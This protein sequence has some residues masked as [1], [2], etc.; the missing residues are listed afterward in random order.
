MKTFTTV[1]LFIIVGLAAVFTVG[2]PERRSIAEIERNPARYQDKEVAIAGVVRD[3]SSA[4]VPGASVTVQNE[5]NGDRRTAVGP[6]CDLRARQQPRMQRAR[7]RPTPG[8]QPRLEHRVAQRVVFQRI[9]RAQRFMFRQRRFVLGQ[10]QPESVAQ[11]HRVRPQQRAAQAVESDERRLVVR[12]HRQS[13]R[14]RDERRFGVV[15][16]GHAGGRMPA[17]PTGGR[18]VRLGCSCRHCRHPRRR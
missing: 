13:P 11:V 7:V 14:R 6:R 8:T 16:R 2:C 12:A 15:A 3:S 1:I 10:A 5:A 18:A 9:R 17:R 4:G